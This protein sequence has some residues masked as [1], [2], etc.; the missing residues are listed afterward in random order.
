MRTGNEDSSIL[1][2]S[3]LSTNEFDLGS[4]IVD[5]SAET[6]LDRLDLLRD[7]TED[8]FFESIELVET[9][10]RSDLTQS[11]EDP[12]HRL[13]VERLVATEYENESSELHT[14]RLDRFRLSCNVPSR[15]VDCS[16]TSKT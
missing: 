7:S 1:A 15:S 2:Q 4:R 14:E 12:S 3:K 6:E 16:A 9:S 13:K 10:P 8:A 11:N 5:S